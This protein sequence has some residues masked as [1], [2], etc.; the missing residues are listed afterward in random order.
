M[1][2][3]KEVQKALKDLVFQIEDYDS[4]SKEIQFGEKWIDFEVKK[5]CEN[6]E[7]EVA[8]LTVWDEDA[9]QIKLS[10]DEYFDICKDIKD[11]T[12]YKELTNL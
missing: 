8:E 11:S 4:I 1:T 3:V 12:Y 2:I 9:E 5:D 6:S 10:G 7:V